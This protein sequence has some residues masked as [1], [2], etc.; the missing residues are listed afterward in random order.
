VL[1]TLGADA[2]ALALGKL[3]SRRQSPPRPDAMA[4]HCAMVANPQLSA[5]YSVMSRRQNSP[6]AA[7][8]ALL[9]NIAQPTAAALKLKSVFMFS[10]QTCSHLL[11]GRLQRHD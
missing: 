3:G 7:G 6:A 1:R 10:L 9:K 5:P 11:A 2:K 4:W 8:A